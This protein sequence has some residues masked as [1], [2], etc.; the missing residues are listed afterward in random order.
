MSNNDLISRE[1]LKKAIT[2]NRNIDCNAV[3]DVLDVI[4]NAPTVETI[5]IEYKAYN[6]GFKDGVEQG[7]KLSERP[8]GKWIE[9]KHRVN[10]LIG[11]LYSNQV[12]SKSD[13]EYIED[14]IKKLMK[15]K[16]AG[17][18]MR[19]EENEDYMH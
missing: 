1:A 17:A 16:K 18:D 4:D 2:L 19:G 9:T 14:S 12:I 3:C 8:Q 6:E 7:I 5:K 15:G 11:V 13:L 10:L